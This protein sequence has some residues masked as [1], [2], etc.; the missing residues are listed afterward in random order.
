MA[1]KKE[2]QGKGPK[3]GGG[4]APQ[5]PIGC[6]VSQC[7]GKDSRFGFCNEHYEHF[8]FGLVKKNRTPALAGS[9]RDR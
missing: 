1:G 6:A 8:K 4:G 9:V 3:A 5:G 2:K 7:K